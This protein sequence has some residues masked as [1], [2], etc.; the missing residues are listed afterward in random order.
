MGDLSVSRRPRGTAGT[1]RLLVSVSVDVHPY[2][3]D[4][5]YPLMGWRIL[6]G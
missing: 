6:D 2:C 4:T 3:A 1:R 5:A